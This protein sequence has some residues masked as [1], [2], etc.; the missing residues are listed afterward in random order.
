MGIKWIG[1]HFNKLKRVLAQRALFL[2]LWEINRVSVVNVLPY[3]EFV[4]NVW[5]EKFIYLLFY[6]YL[7]LL[8]TS[9]LMRRICI[10]GR[11]DEKVGQITTGMTCFAFFCDCATRSQL[12]F[13]N[14]LITRAPS[15][16]N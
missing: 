6:F 5:F 2:Q 4:R 3:T 10:Y 11:Y 13:F 7:P 15:S 8:P 14:S 9:L 1:M 12:S 16:G